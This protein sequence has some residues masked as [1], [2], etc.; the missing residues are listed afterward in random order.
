MDRRT[1]EKGIKCKNIGGGGQFPCFC[2]KS[3]VTP[4]MEANDSISISEEE[5]EKKLDGEEKLNLTEAPETEDAE[6]VVSEET[7]SNEE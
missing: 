3:V 4:V 5:E 1:K 6:V 2:R 7:D